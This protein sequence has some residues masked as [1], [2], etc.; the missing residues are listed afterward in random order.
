MHTIFHLFSCSQPVRI[1]Q[2]CSFCF[3]SNL[4]G[5]GSPVKQKQKRQEQ[6]QDQKWEEELFASDL[7]L[8]RSG[9]S[10]VR[11]GCPPSGVRPRWRSGR[12]D[13]HVVLYCLVVTVWPPD[14][15][16][17]VLPCAHLREL[18]LLHLGLGAPP[19]QGPSGTY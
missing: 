13:C 3:T 14:L 11:T 19:L 2:V 8:D 7:S 10:P 17:P 15:G 5:G 9:P 16:V 6:E 18:Y 12:I 4:Q 1:S